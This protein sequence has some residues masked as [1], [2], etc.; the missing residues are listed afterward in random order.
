MPD[1]PLTVTQTGEREFRAVYEDEVFPYR[2][3]F[4]T[5]DEGEE[6]LVKLLP[7]WENQKLRIAEA[8]GREMVL[9]ESRQSKADEIFVKSA[10]GSPPDPTFERVLI[11]ILG[12]DA[13]EHHVRVHKNETTE[14]VK[15]GLKRLH[16]GINPAKI[17][18][19]GSELHDADP[20]TDWATATGSSPMRVK[21][22]LDTPMQ[23][24]WLWQ[25]TGLRDLGTKIGMDDRGTR[26]G[27]A[28]KS[29]AHHPLP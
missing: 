26:F 19:E 7:L 16:R 14:F 22:T 12:D 8:F 6:H 20:L 21:V 29:T 27:R 4:V 3:R 25:H 24:F 11:Y 13:T 15:E 10:D 23:K 2:V 18:F 1:P 9:D 28:F 17:L 5:N